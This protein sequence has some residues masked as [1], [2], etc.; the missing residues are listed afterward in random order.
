MT[1]INKTQNP[2]QTGGF[3][4]FGRYYFQLQARKQL[5]EKIVVHSDASLWQR[6]FLVVKLK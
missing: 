6:I 2:S 4:V 1:R 5:F 3:C